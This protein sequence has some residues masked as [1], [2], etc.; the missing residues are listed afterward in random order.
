MS[1]RRLRQVAIVLAVLGLGV[2][3]YLTYIHYE[4]IKPVCGLGGDC[5]KVQ[6]S[7][8]AYL[9]GVP[10]ALLGLIGYAVILAT[11]FIE[12]EE[13]L[14]AGALVALVGAGFSAYL[15]Y[16]ELFTIDAICPWCVASAIIVT[17]LAIVTIAR[18][19][20]A[21][22]EHRGAIPYVG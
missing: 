21:P 13:A 12:R 8:W 9:A 6:T 1:D 15:T 18:L 4:G 7:E 22:T 5:E 2:A 10:V 20:R 11:L 16:R 3:G 17:L 19:L 14:I